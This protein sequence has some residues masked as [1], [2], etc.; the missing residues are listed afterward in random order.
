MKIIFLDIDGVLNVISHDNDKYGSQFHEHF[1]KNLAEL[2]RITDAK[3]VISSSWRKS[4]L[5][6][7]Q[8]M[9]L[10]RRLPGEIIDVTPSLYLKRGGSIRFWNGKERRHPTERIA[11]YSIPRGV[12]IQ[13]W[14]KNESARFGDIKS[15]VILDDDTDMLL[16]QSKHYVRC[17]CLTHSDA[18]EG[19]GLTGGCA[20][21]AESILM[22]I[23][24]KTND[25]GF[26]EY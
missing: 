11:S 10:E 26:K 19:Y 14:L 21:D 6:E 16:S 25:L 13:Y 4:G 18:I 20:H 5:A 9:W 15:Y 24:V 1:V 3:I 8:D 17:S 7:M 22:D 23:T 2:I 12:E